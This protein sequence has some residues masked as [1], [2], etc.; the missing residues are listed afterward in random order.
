MILFLL[1]MI[2]GK[3]NKKS[4]SVLDT[5]YARARK[6]AKDRESERDGEKQRIKY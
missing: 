3:G 5:G 6:R 1:M 2:L 4:K